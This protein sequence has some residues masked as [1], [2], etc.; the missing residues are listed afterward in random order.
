MN[1]DANGKVG[2]RWGTQS[3]NLHNNV[4]QQKKFYP[5]QQSS[6]NTSVA[7]TVESQSPVVTPSQVAENKDLVSTQLNSEKPAKLEITKD[8]EPSV[9][10]VPKNQPSG[11]VIEEQVTENQHSGEQN[12]K[13]GSSEGVSKQKFEEKVS[14]F[15]KQNIPRGR[16]PQGNRRVHTVLDKER[17]KNKVKYKPQNQAEQS[18]EYNLTQ[19]GYQPQVYTK[20]PLDQGNGTNIENP[21]NPEDPNPKAPTG[22]ETPVNNGSTTSVPTS[23][24]AKKV[25]EGI[26]AQDRVPKTMGKY[27]WAKYAVGA[28]V[29]GGLVLSLS[30][31]RGQ[32]TNAQLYGQRPLY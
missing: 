29:L 12:I 23:K 16:Y 6:V 10:E 22:E 19:A 9:A 7:E 28:T 26:K 15:S 13:N 18:S 20:T 30:D 5:T 25:E 1:K 2:K 14:T 11:N 24:N 21:T 17:G 31:S 4:V 8:V 27:K 32:Q 3:R